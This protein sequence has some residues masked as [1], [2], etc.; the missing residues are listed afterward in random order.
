MRMHLLS[1]DTG[2]S[3]ILQERKDGVETNVEVWMQEGEPLFAF[4]IL[5]SKKKYAMD[6]GELVGCA[7]DFAF[8]IPLDCKAVTDSVGILYPAYKKTQYTGLADAN[9]IASRDG[10]WF[11]ERCERLGYNAHLAW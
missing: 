7:F 4:M 6:M 2:G 3:F 9:F 10:L 5:E 8:T 11:F 1:L